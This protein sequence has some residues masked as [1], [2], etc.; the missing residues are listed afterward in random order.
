MIENKKISFINLG[1]KVNYYE[2]ESVKKMAM[3]SGFTLA[4]DHKE[5][6]VVVINTCT[7]TNIADQKTRK[8]IRRVKKENPGAIVV[9]MGCYVQNAKMEN[10]QIPEEADIVL[11]TSEKDSFLR[12]LD[13]YEGKKL[14]VV[15]KLTKDTPYGELPPPSGMERTRAFLKVEDGCNAFCS[16]CIIPYVRGPVRSKDFTKA[17]EEAKRMADGGY[18]EIVLNGIHLCSYGK[19]LMDGGNTRKEKGLV[20]LVEELGRIDKVERIRLSSLEP[21]YLTEDVIDRLSK[22]KKLCPHFHIS[23][24][25]G[26]DTVLE[27]MGRNY[28]TQSYAGI[29]DDIRRYFDDPAITTDIIVGFPGE[30]RNE[31]EQTLDFVRRM[32]FFTVHVFPYSRRDGTA[33]ALMKNQIENKEKSERASRLRHLSEELGEKY[34]DRHIGKELGILAEDEVR[35]GGKDYLRGHTPEYIEAYCEKSLVQNGAFTGILGRN[36]LNGKSFLELCGKM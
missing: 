10:K 33:A 12:V 22:V 11:G 8:T 6:G 32:E 15:G 26:S 17:V 28:D 7:V 5:A 23:L 3:D 27:R 35:I 9:A 31:E 24:Q 30:T 14:S 25:S 19:D 13:E 16:Y 21:T 20:D 29:V 36:F 34:I 2:I 4:K 18:R 1:C